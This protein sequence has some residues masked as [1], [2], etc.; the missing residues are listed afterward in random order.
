V[1]PDVAVLGRKD[2]QQ[3]QVVR[4]MAIDLDL[5]VEVVGVTTVRGP[6]GLARSS[7]NRRLDADARA[8]ARRVPA[9]LAAAVLHARSERA[10]GAAGASGDPAE[11]VRAAR[12]LL[13]VP[14]IEVDYVEA[15]DPDTL[16]AHDVRPGA[17]VL[18]AV[19]VHVGRGAARVRLIDNVVV[20]DAD[21]ED[22]LLAAIATAPDT[23]DD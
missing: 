12:D 6:G 3:L 16:R 8:L 18:V 4:R 1:R 7:R 5:G 21:D 17:P 19:A 13:D 2:F 23:L 22:A 20:G 15:V 9:A 10:P 11:L 14:G